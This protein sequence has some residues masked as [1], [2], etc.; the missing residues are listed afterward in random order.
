MA[1]GLWQKKVKSDPRWRVESAGSWSIEG[2]PA[3]ENTIV[4]LTR[5][6]I[7]LH[8]H[9]SRGVSRELLAQ[10]DLILV[11][12][13]GHKE[14]ISIEFP[15]FKSKVFLL[16]EMVGEQYNIQDPV[17]G[18]L[19]DFEA[20]AQEFEQIFERGYARIVQLAQG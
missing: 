13:T 15:E 1:M 5:R 18:S 3:A 12:E 4:V 10:F 9:R 16:S 17:G 11:M 14:A 20:T 2:V 6:G 19:E 7:D 8:K